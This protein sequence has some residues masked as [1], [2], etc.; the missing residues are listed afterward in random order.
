MTTGHDVAMAL[1]TA[2]LIW[3]RR[4]DA[5]FAGRGVTADQF[6]LATGIQSPL[7]S[8]TVGQNIPVFPA[9]GFSITAP[10]LDDAATPTV[11]GVDEKT[12]VA[13]SRLGWRRRFAA[14]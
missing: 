3:H 2:Y 10:V 6:V 14:R 11:G 4:V 12:L 1:R 7:L 5:H 8:R 9:K 13:W